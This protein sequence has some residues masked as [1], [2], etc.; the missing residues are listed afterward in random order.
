GQKTELQ[1]NGTPQ[2]KT[3]SKCS[4]HI[5][6]ILGVQNTSD[7]T[8]TTLKVRWSCCSN[9]E[10]EFNLKWSYKLKEDTVEKLQE[11]ISATS[12]IIKDLPSNCDITVNVCHTKDTSWSPCA[13]FKTKQSPANFSFDVNTAHIKLKLSPDSKS[14][15]YPGDEYNNASPKSPSRFTFA[16][17]VLGNI[18]FYSGRHYWEIEVNRNGWALGVAYRGVARN[19]WLGSNDSSW[20][21]HYN[22]CKFEYKVRHAGE[23]TDVTPKL[24][25]S[26][27]FIKRVGV[28]LNYD[29]GI[30]KFLDCTRRTVMYTYVVKSFEQ[31]VCAAANPFYHG[32]Y[33]TLVSGLDIPNYIHDV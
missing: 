25:T 2:S 5:P 13:I 18:S 31:P 33:L 20:I 15:Y 14:V 32:G 4:F 1:T 22:P 8:K 16:L 28:F 3:C 27:S 30:I 6:L 9:C 24:N 29:A 26:F 12:F 17:N 10:S 7:V 23:A 11:G 21:L 19:S